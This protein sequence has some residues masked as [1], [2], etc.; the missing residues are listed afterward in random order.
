MQLQC[1]R[2]RHLQWRFL[3]CKLEEAML[4]AK[5]KV[6]TQSISV[7]GDGGGGGVGRGTSTISAYGVEKGNNQ[8]QHAPFSRRDLTSHWSLIMQPAFVL[9][10]LHAYCA[11]RHSLSYGLFH[12]I[13]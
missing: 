13:L 12:M 9:L 3:N 7:A 8:R 10:L 11:F 2:W 6:H 5:P 4:A 1:E